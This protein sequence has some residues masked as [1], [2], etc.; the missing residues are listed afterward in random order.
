MDLVENNPHQTV[1][2]GVFVGYPHMMDLGS[3]RK[4]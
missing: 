1:Q 3:G 4:R 2:F